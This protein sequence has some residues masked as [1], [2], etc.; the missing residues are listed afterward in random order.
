MGERAPLLWNRS[1]NTQKLHV[2]DPPLGWG[3]TN[4]NL[5]K[6]ESKKKRT[7]IHHNTVHPWFIIQ[8]QVSVIQHSG[9]L[10]GS[11][12]AWVNLH[13]KTLFFGLAIDCT[14]T[15]QQPMSSGKLRVATSGSMTISELS[16]GSKVLLILG[17]ATATN[18]SQMNATWPRPASA[19]TSV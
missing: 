14:T 1:D 16:R 12:Q 8:A 19:L 15:E 13:L 10:P 17:A 7:A 9:E 3:T 4:R 2:S 11:R 5:T 18:C 6:K